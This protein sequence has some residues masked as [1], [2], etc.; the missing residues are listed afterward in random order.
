MMIPDEYLV[1]VCASTLMALGIG[2]DA[3]LATFV[4]SGQFKNNWQATYWIAGVVVTHTIFPMAGYFLA[5]MSVQQVPILAPIIGVCAFILVAHFL[6]T[7]LL[8]ESEDELNHSS[9]IT[10]G[11]ILAVSW[12]ALWSGPA[13]SAQ[14]LDWS[15]W[16]IWLSFFWVGAVVCLLCIGSFYFGRQLLLNL[17]DN[18]RVLSFMLWL[19]F[20]VIGYFGWLALFRYTFNWQLNELLVFCLS[21]VIVCIVQVRQKQSQQTAWQV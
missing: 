2:I 15:Q 17:K 13:K 3:A 8:Q 6:Y 10:M 14:V 19:Q 11:L 16:M 9:W 21:G 20:S 18:P 4:R 12:D 5:Y 1:F 7:E